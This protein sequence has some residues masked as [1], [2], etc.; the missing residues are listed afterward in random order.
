[1]PSVGECQVWVSWEEKY[2]IIVLHSIIKVVLNKIH[3]THKK[4]A[5][6][7][8]GF[9]LADLWGCSETSKGIR[10]TVTKVK[11][12]ISKLC[13]TIGAERPADQNSWC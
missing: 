11:D 8:S 1:M 6:S 9:P 3:G 10:K 12:C 2:S 4:A 13:G 5:P 7:I